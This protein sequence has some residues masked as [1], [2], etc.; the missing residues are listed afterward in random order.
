MTYNFYKRF[1]AVLL[2]F[3]IPIALIHMHGAE[4]D[5]FMQ[6]PMLFNIARC[7]YPVFSILFL[8]FG[9]YSHLCGIKAK[10]KFE[11]PTSWIVFGSI[12]T[13]LSLGPPISMYFLFP[14]ISVPPLSDTKLQTFIQ[15]SINPN[16][17]P[18]TRVAA[19]KLYYWETKDR[20]DYLDGS[21]NKR[22][23]T[24]DEDDEKHL[25]LVSANQQ[26]RLA[27]KMYV[28]GLMILAAISC[29][30]FLFFVALKKP[31]KSAD[32]A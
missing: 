11:G 31:G 10:R 4:T 32:S 23:Y 26:N 14:D 28:F 22:V 30:G 29:A 15:T 27:R 25:R 1:P 12:F 9:I 8:Y 13:L 2:V 7:A 20:I 18:D 16:E 3:F 24:P 5:W 17:E 21:G 6:R 19:A